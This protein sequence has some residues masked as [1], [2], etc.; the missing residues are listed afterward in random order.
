MVKICVLKPHLLASTEDIVI[1]QLI[2]FYCRNQ[3]QLIWKSQ[4]SNAIS[5]FILKL[6]FLDVIFEFIP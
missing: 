6:Y 1:S 4:F 2:P 3:F 5:K